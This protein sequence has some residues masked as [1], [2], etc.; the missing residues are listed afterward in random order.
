MIAQSDLYVPERTC[1]L[2]NTVDTDKIDAAYENGTLILTLYKKE[3]KK[4][5]EI[6]INVA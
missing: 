3:E 4:T 5:K 6:K 1:S 2:N